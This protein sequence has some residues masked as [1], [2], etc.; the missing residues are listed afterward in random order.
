MQLVTKGLYTEVTNLSPNLKA[1]EELTRPF[2]Y[3]LS[4][5]P[6]NT[7]TLKCG[8]MGKESSSASGKSNFQKAAASP[9]DC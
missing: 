2:S 3:P 5:F 1:E 9:P 4:T 6:C 8:L 7:S